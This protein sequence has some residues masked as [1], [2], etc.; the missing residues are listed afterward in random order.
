MCGKEEIVEPH[1]RLGGFGVSVGILGL[2][3]WR[4]EKRG[5]GEGVADEAEDIEGRE[6]DCEAKGRFAEVI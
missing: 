3:G 1:R 6:V 2:D 5:R 4:V